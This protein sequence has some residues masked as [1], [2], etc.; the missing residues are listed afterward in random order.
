[1]MSTFLQVF[2][3]QFSTPA[4][5]VTGRHCGLSPRARRRQTHAPFHQ[6]TVMG[7]ETVLK[8]AMNL[9]VVSVNHTEI[10]VYNEVTF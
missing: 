3:T 6:L 8:A 10:Y 2:V 5:S 4:Q 9:A 1:M 7:R